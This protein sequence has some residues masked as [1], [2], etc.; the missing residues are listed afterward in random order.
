MS[1]KREFPILNGKLLSDLDLNGHKLLGLNI[2]EGGGGGGASVTVDDTLTQDGENPVKSK[3]IWSAIWGAIAAPAASVYA[4]VTTEL[5]KKQDK[6]SEAQ[7]AAANSGITAEKVGKLN[8]IEAGAQKNPDLS[9]YAKK[10]DIPA[11]PDLSEYAKTAEVL[12]RYLFEKAGFK[13]VEEFYE[14]TI[15]IAPYTNAIKNMGNYPNAIY[16]IEVADG[17]G[18]HCRDCV[19]RLKVPDGISAPK[20]LWGTN[21]H[22]R[23]DAETDFACEVGVRNVY[24]ITE[25]APDEFTVAGWQETAGGNA[26][27]SQ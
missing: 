21:F 16:T 10:T 2:P 22:P 17:D 27:D 19:L 23:T 8:G 5:G 11:A 25:H 9:G 13:W 20:L 4:W 7:L 6:L 12:P 18:V 24:W 26:N 15:T 1:E 3:G 14:A